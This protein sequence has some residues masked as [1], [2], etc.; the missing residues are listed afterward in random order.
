MSVSICGG[1]IFGG[2]GLQ[3]IRGRAYILGKGGG[4][5]VGGLRYYLDIDGSIAKLDIDS[6]KEHHKISITANF[7]YLLRGEYRYPVLKTVSIWP[8]ILKYKT[9]AFI[10]I[11]QTSRAFIFDIFTTFRD[12]TLQLY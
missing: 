2:G 6:W 12:Q 5:I 3:Y 7:V 4:L 1:L 11:F 9:I 8:R 10:Q